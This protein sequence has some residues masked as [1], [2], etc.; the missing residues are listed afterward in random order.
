MTSVPTPDPRFKWVGAFHSYDP[1]EIAIGG[2]GANFMAQSA[3]NDIAQI[4]EPA[5]VSNTG[6]TLDTSTA[7]R[8]GTAAVVSSAVTS[9]YEFWDT[10]TA[11]TPLDGVQVVTSLDYPTHAIMMTWTTVANLTFQAQRVQ[12]TGASEITAELTTEIAAKRVPTAI[13]YDGSAIQ[14]ISY[15]QDTDTSSYDGMSMLGSAADVDADATALA[16]SGYT[17]TAF[18]RVDAGSDY[19]II[20]T[21]VAGS[22]ATR[23][24]SIVADVDS[25]KTLITQ[26]WVIVAGYVPDQSQPSKAR[27][28]LQQ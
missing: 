5:V 14:L 17:I 8:G 22:S 10:A 16:G 11:P 25:V 13:A 2:A 19:A 15:R 18:G 9:G 1:Y 21:R 26:G 20:G 28:I 4:W 24:V 3:N 12:L 27:W 23:A 7:F 6:T